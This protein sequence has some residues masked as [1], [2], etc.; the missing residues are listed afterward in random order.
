MGTR[1]LVCYSNTAGFIIQAVQNN[2]IIIDNEIGYISCFASIILEIFR[3]KEIENRSLENMTRNSY[4][5]IMGVNKK[6]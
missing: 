3:L 5:F 4:H 2:F 1:Y 6:P